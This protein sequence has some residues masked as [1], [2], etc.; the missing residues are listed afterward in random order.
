MAAAKPMAACCSLSVDSSTI[1][2]MGDMAAPSSNFSSSLSSPHKLRK[3]V[4]A[5]TP[6]GLLLRLRSL[7]QLLGHWRTSKNMASPALMA[8]LN[9]WLFGAVSL[10]N[11]AIKLWITPPVA[12]MQSLSSSSVANSLITSTARDRP[13][14]PPAPANVLKSSSDRRNTFLD[15]RTSRKFQSSSWINAT[16]MEISPLVL[17]IRTHVL[18]STASLLRIASPYLCSSGTIF[19][20]AVKREMMASRDPGIAEILKQLLR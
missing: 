8:M 14:S 3:I 20:P 7:E 9:W 10:A 4:A 13:E 15:V 2:M 6:I 1:W 16:R 18:W 17:P 12:P 5:W 19:S 11:M